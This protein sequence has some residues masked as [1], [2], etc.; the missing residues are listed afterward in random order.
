M[1]TTP[2]CTERVCDVMYEYCTGLTLGGLPTVGPLV[3][4]CEGTL[5]NNNIVV[6]GLRL[7]A[8]E[9]KLQVPL[10]TSERGNRACGEDSGFCWFCAIDATC[11]YGFHMDSICTFCRT[12][13]HC[14]GSTVATV[15]LVRT[16]YT[17][18]AALELTCVTCGPLKETQRQASRNLPNWERTEGGVRPSTTKLRELRR[19]Y[20]GHEDEAV[21]SVR[22]VPACK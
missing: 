16:E 5:H 9:T 4:C 6:E 19:R 17:L 11:T 14:A 2:L 22:L 12:A 7:A 21:D 1:L 3:R 8:V 15:L 20:E 13:T 10:P 18:G